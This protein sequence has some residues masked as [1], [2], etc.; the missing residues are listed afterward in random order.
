MCVGYLGLGGRGEVGRLGGRE[1]GCEE[2]KSVEG[3]YRRETKV[4]GGE[5]WQEGRIGNPV[6]P[7]P[8]KGLFYQ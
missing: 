1:E 7:H 4:E 6:Q 3:R 8:T 2:R 5:K